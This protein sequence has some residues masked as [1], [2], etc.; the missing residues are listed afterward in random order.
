MDSN[1]IELLEREANQAVAKI[2]IVTSNVPIKDMPFPKDAFPERLIEILEHYHYYRSFPLDFFAVSVLTAAGSAFGNSHVLRT[3]DGYTNRANTYVMIVAQ[4][5]I[6]KSAPLDVA[7]QPIL[8]EQ[9]RMFQKFKAQQVQDKINKSEQK[10][11][12]KEQA[13][14]AKKNAKC[15]DNAEKVQPETTYQDIEKENVTG[16]SA[17]NAGPK[18]IKPIM[19]GTTTEAL[20]DQLSY[21][22][23]GVTILYDELAG[24]VNS[25]DKYRKGETFSCTYL[26]SRGRT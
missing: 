26:Y 17:E 1:V 2:E 13:A 25:L 23:H 14:E 24:F 11:L 3:P 12:A 16:N 22:P 10:V 20:I 18:F 6:N 9:I 19:Q 8:A 7:Y 15:K 4:P 5:G 21:N